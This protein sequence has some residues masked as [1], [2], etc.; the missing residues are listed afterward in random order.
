[1]FTSHHLALVKLAY[2]T[3]NIDAA[4]PILEKDIVFYPSG[5]KFADSRPPCDPDVPPVGYITVESGLTQ[6]V[7]SSDVMQYDLLRGLAFIQ[8]RAW[9][10]AFEALERVV[11]Y[12][13]KDSHACS[14]IMVEAHNK[15]ILVGLLLN[16]HAPAL[17]PTTSP[18][19]AK[20]YTT[21]SK[22]YLALA[23]AFEERTPDNLRAEFDAV[24]A[25]V[26]T[27]ENNLSLVR[28]V[29]RHYQRWQILNM[30]HVYTKIPLSQIRAR[31]QSAE[32]GAPLATDAEVEDLVGQMIQEGMLRG[33]VEHPDNG[34]PYLR[35]LDE[36]EGSS[37]RS[38]A[39]A[40]SGEKDGE[41][42]M[43]EAEF[44][45]RM[46]EAAQRIKGLEPLVR[47]ANERLGKTK[48]YIRFL[49]KEQKEK[50]R[51]ERGAAAGQEYVDSFMAQ[52]EDEDLMMGVAS[53]Y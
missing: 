41:G 30:R 47:A 38:S 3:D 39:G 50:E 20:A 42:T 24:P 36:A 19:P 34:E 51:A 9:R 28:L 48:E 16:G 52:V 53:K 2:T 15:W 25:N 8:R 21:L 1:M 44:A 29:I 46:A 12:P 17:P 27:E 5:K 13:V 7:S 14:K 22:P 45:A 6:K 37:S 43:T 35:F 31:T 4:L 23:R 10:A 49:V 40:E 33:V 26:W 32:T 11:T 18:G